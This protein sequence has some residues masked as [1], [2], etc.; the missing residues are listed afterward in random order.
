M[1]FSVLIDKSGAIVQKKAGYTP[2]D[3]KTLAAEIDKQ[4]K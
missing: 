3:E 1:P 2:G 4:L